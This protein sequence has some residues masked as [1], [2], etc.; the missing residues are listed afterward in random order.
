MSP[1]VDYKSDRQPDPA[2]DYSRRFPGFTARHLLTRDRKP[3]PDVIQG[4][5]VSTELL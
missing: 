3:L 2:G 4:R 1:Y 5:K